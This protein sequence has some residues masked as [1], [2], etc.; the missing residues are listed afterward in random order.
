MENKISEISELF[1]NTRK[2]TLSLCDNL[3]PEDMVI[4]PS[5]NVS[6]IKWH[7]GH[8]TWFFEKF[9]LTE[10]NENYKPFNKDYNYI[11]NSYYNSVGEFNPRNKRGA[12]NRPLLK[13]IIKYRNYVT[14]NILD[15]IKKTKN[16]T[17]S[18]L[19]ELGSNHEQQHQELILMDIKNI[20][21]NNPLMPA[22]NPIENTSKKKS[23]NEFF[24][25]SAKKFTYGNDEDIFCYDNELPVAEK[26]LDPFKIYAMVTNGEWKNFIDD[27]GYKN[28]EYWLSD[29][30]DFIKNNK[31]ER[32]MYWIDN[33]NYFTLNGVKKI[34]NDKPVSHISFY[35]ADAYARYKNKRLPSEF[36]LEYYLKQFSKKGN[37]LE[38]KIYHEVEEDSENVYGNLWVW[39]NSNYIPYKKYKPYEGN[40]GEYNNKF[41]C[42]QF[43]LKGGSHSTSKNH[44]RASYRNFF[45]P[46]DTWQ[47]CGVRLADD[48]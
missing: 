39:T 6:P 32:P 24:S 34:D 27:G 36:E 25:N 47:F 43:V 38:N 4:Q 13:D 12:L 37:F 46:S 22:F 33:N 29:G 16:N 35:E 1:S 18:F 15:F 17:I 2:Q 20:F 28:H 10:M 26:Y 23:T 31:L 44:I 48:I 3:E 8:T 40:L 45:Y 21:Y 9:I 30:W 41:M 42:N 11:F 7:L 5:K 14:E 19:V